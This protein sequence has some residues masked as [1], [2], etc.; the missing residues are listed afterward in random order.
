MKNKEK[1]GFRPLTNKLELGL[2][3][4]LEKRR[5]FNEK[6]GLGL[7]EKREVLRCLSLNKTG[8]TLKYI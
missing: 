3:W 8:L 2:G 7:R 1:N 5:S 4:N 6:E